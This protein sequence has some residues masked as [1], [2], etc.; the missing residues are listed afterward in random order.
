MKN[1]EL[2][3]YFLAF[4]FGLSLIISTLASVHDIYSHQHPNF[5]VECNHT[6]NHIEH[7]HSP[8]QGYDMFSC[9]SGMFH[10]FPSANYRY[11]VD[12]DNFDISNRAGCIWQPPKFS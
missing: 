9:E 12:P 10:P 4:C 1:A 3:A 2:T 11:I 7:S 6:A 5:P 8:L